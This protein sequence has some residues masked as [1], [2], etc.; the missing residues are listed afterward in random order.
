LCVLDELENVL[1]PERA[2]SD[3]HRNI[4][5]VLDSEAGDTCAFPARQVRIGAC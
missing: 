1:G 5:G 2:H 4:G 3:D